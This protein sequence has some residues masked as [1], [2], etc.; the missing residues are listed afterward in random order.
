M[1]E[2][3][4]GVVVRTHNKTGG[5]EETRYNHISCKNIPS[6]IIDN[7]IAGE[8]VCVQLMPDVEAFYFKVPV[9]WP[10]NWADMK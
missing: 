4:I 6:D 5:F 1:K 7:L 10:E 9:D 3:N 8:L 2:I